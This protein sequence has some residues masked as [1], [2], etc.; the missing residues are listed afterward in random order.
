MRYGRDAP[1]TVQVGPDEALASCSVAEP[2]GIG[3]KAFAQLSGHFSLSVSPLI[4][5][6]S[7]MTMFFGNS[8]FPT[9]PRAISIPMRTRHVGRFVEVYPPTEVGPSLWRG[10]SG[11]IVVV[12]NPRARGRRV[13]AGQE[14]EL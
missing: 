11:T 10:M 2:A 13:L 1:F 5:R 12:D 6:S 3:G 9:T 14:I 4:D 7:M 8:A